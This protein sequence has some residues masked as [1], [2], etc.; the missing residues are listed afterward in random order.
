MLAWIVGSIK[1]ETIAIFIP[2]LGV[3]GGIMI[4]IVAVI[5][6]GRNKD[7]E[8][9]ERLMAMEKGIA[10]PEPKQEYRRPTYSGRRVAGL[11]ILGF[12]LAL[13]IALWTDAGAEGGVWGLLFVFTGIGLLIAAALDKR[14]Y[15]AAKR[16]EEMSK[17]S[18]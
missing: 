3:L 1:P 10:L 14:E 18:M 16:E 7:L 2:I 6:K 15:E 8:H 11:M 4:A 17:N 5:V 9:R 12:G 13:S